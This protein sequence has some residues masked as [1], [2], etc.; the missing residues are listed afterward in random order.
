M[1]IL[2]SKD[3]Q[4]HYVNDAERGHVWEQIMIMLPKHVL[5][6]MLSAT[7]PNK[8]D[9]ADWLG[10]VRGTEVHVVAT[11]KRPVPLE[12][13]LFTGMDGQRSKDH[14]HLIVDQAGQF[15]LPGYKQ[16]SRMLSGE[17]DVDKK[18]PAENPVNSSNTKNVP[19]KNTGGKVNT[20]GHF[21][22]LPPIN[23]ISVHDH[24]TKNLW[25][26]VVHLLQER[27]LMPA[28]AFAFSRSSLETLAGH[29]SSVD[30]L[31]SSEK[32]Q[33]KNFLHCSVTKRL[34]R[35]DRQLASVQFIS[36][37]AVRGLAVHHAGMLPILKETVEMLFRRGL[38]RILFA[39]ETFAMGVN[40]P[41]RCV[42]FTT[43]EK[44]DGQKRRPLSSSE[45]TQMAG[46]AGR[47][48]LDASG[49]VI[50]LLGG[51]GKSLTPGSFGLPSEHTLNDIILGRQTQL[52]SKFK[53]TYSMI[54]HLHRTN[55]LTP[56]DVMR[57]S[58]M[59]AANLRRELERR[60]WLSALNKKLDETTTLIPPAGLSSNVSSH[61]LVRGSTSKVA[62]SMNSSSRLSVPIGEPILQVKCP[63]GQISC[64]D[65]M[66]TYYQACCNYQK[67]TAT[68]VRLLAEE[69]IS[70]LQRV[71][72]PGRIVFVHLPQTDHSLYSKVPVKQPDWLV[73]GV[74]VNLSKKKFM[75][76]SEIQWDIIT[77]QLPNLSNHS[78]SFKISNHQSPIQ[79]NSGN[80][81]NDGKVES[82]TNN[83]FNELDEEDI[84]KEGEDSQLSNTP[85]PPQ[86]MPV[87]IPEAT[88]ARE[89]IGGHLN[90]TDLFYENILPSEC[91]VTKFG[92]MKTEAII[93]RAVEKVRDSVFSKVGSRLSFNRSL[94]KPGAIICESQ[95]VDTVLDASLSVVSRK[96]LADWF[97]STEI[98]ISPSSHT[99]S[100]NHD[101]CAD[102][103]RRTKELLEKRIRNSKPRQSY[104]FQEDTACELP[105][106]TELVDNPAFKWEFE[107]DTFQKQAILCLE[108]NQTVFVAA[109]TSAGKTVVAEYAC[110]L[111]Q[112][113]GTRVIYTSPIKAL[114]NQKFYDFRQTFGDD[115]GLITG[116]IKLAPESTILVM[117]TEIL[118]NMLCNDAD[119]IRDLEIV[120]MDEVHYVN[121]AE[122]GHVWE[123]IMIMLPKHVLLVMLSATVPN[124]L[125]FADWL[126]RV[127]GTEVHVVATNKRPVPLEHFLFTGMD[128]Q[129]SKDHLHLIVDQAGQFNLPGK[130]KVRRLVTNFEDTTTELPTLKK[131][132]PNP[133]LNWYFEL[134]TFQKR[135]ILCLENN[136]TVFVA[137]HTS[138]G[139]TV[140]AEYACAICLRRGSRVIYTSPV[141]ALSNQ[142]FHDFREKFGENVGIIT[143]DIKLAPT[144][145]LLVMTTEILHSILCNASETINDLE[146][147]ILDEVHYINNPDRGYIW[148]QIMIML[149]RHIL[150]VLLSAT[151]PNTYEL[152]DWLG[153]VRGCKIHVVATDR[154]PV[155]LEHYLYT[156]NI[157]QYA[158]HLHLI[159]DENGRFINSGYEAAAV[160]NN[161]R[162][163]TYTPGLRGKDGFSMLTK[164]TWLGFIN[165]LKEQD[166]MPVIAFIFSRSVLE[167]LARNLSSI[168]LTSQTEKKQINKFFSTNIDRLKKCNRKLGSIR[169]VRDLTR[170]GFA[171][172]HGGMLPLLKEIVEVL[173][174]KGLVKILFATETFSM[175]INTPARSV[176]FTS[177]EKFDGQNLRPLNP[178]EYTQMA[179]RAGRRGVDDKGHVIILVSTIRRSIKS[180]LTGLPTESTLRTM[181]L[182]AQTQLVSKFKVTYS[183]ILSLHRLSSLTPQDVM[184]RSFMEAASHRWETKQR[185]DL[186]L[187]NNKLNE[188][189]AISSHNKPIDNCIQSTQATTATSNLFKSLTN[190]LDVQVKCPNNGLECCHS[191]SQYYELC[192]K[193]RQLKNSIICK[194]DEKY[195]ESLPK[196]FCPG[197][198]ILFESTIKQCVWLVPAVII[199]Y[200]WEKRKHGAG[201]QLMLNT[202]HWTLPANLPN[203]STFIN[204]Q[205]HV[206]VVVSCGNT[207][208]T[209]KQLNDSKNSNY[210]E[211][212][213]IEE[214][215]IERS[216][217]TEITTVQVPPHLMPVFIPSS[218]EDGY[219]RLTHR[220][221]SLSDSLVRICNRIVTFQSNKSNPTD[222][223][224]DNFEF[225][226][227]LS[228]ILSQSIK[229]HN[230]QQLKNNQTKNNVK[231]SSITVNG[232]DHLKEI[233]LELCNCVNATIPKKSVNYYTTLKNIPKQIDFRKDLNFNI[234]DEEDICLF[235]A[236]CTLNDQLTMPLSNDTITTLNLINLLK[237]PNLLQHLN[238]VHQTIRRK[239][240]IKNIQNNLANYQLQLSNE[241]T[242][243][244]NVLKELGFIDSTT[245]SYCLSF[246][247]F[248]A[249]ELMTKEVLLTQL[250]LDNLIDNLLAP[251]IA[252]V[253][254]AF[255]SELRAQDI[256]GEGASSCY[257]QVLIDSINCNTTTTT[258]FKCH[259]DLKHIPRHLLPVFKTIL[260]R[261]YELEKLQ[262]LHHL[263]DP[264]LESRL[265]LQIV[266]SVHKWANGY[267][268]PATLSTCDLPEGLLIKSLLQLDELIRCICGVCRQFGN[269]ALGLKINEARSLIRRDIVCSP[270]LY[271]LQDTENCL[272]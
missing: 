133:A 41:A 14:L 244:L 142:K 153:R 70:D 148:E 185:Q 220:S 140:V 131:L 236:Y 53:I 121:D 158:S 64:C 229:Q 159:V 228:E 37:L 267:S 104:I 122:R 20:P 197:R 266:Q 45:Y 203:S 175:G 181:I 162:R 118:H 135:A 109:H 202:I 156:G 43:L 184:K 224:D 96:T 59:E 226:V 160:S 249:S 143:G 233:N 147:V 65:S 207:T 24:R 74:L 123:Q 163:L 52:V 31:N 58:F 215:I 234:T 81:A 1:T 82:N 7:V 230:H 210:N 19:R 8:L 161:T 194:L 271:V 165:L 179:G 188:T 116:D 256:T 87:Y 95:A 94:L 106:L 132:I 139:K 86:L 171:I 146:I 38:I 240:A 71:F 152:A 263:T 112:R 217:I 2:G 177:I 5:L 69:N 47:R 164:N 66:T 186:S 258:N 178:S 26:G 232:N 127:R 137:A 211:Y 154:R 57:R 98:N 223:D 219:S 259:E 126:G 238:L 209:S 225:N 105:P 62:I 216:R 168:D 205:G 29:L 222:N 9:F 21:R 110:A 251:D 262:R 195:P 34:K 36:K 242:G 80:N 157:E 173:F 269:H 201:N 46:R 265:N 23:G 193:Y 272:R 270:S 102:I 61:Q 261:A 260:T 227:H 63:F 91:G 18:K 252:A 198:L 72:C 85:Y 39:T 67:L 213:V 155:P 60:Q 221:I 16:A 174:Q 25:L 235:D 212:D 204:E 246:K 108:R 54:L 239:L 77:W 190:D 93:V 214:E 253:L 183:M 257:L 32:Q 3:T 33:V 119:V 254:S 30:L 13:F 191:I 88:I 28:I 10:R 83:Q 237:C 68:I 55:W 189:T 11:N 248:F 27:D 206:D 92:E 218:L 255:A 99:E 101:K 200:Y 124:K 250:L 172:H 73:P 113:R 89:C 90:C 136:K 247:G 138:S 115:V 78:K 97:G 40:M 84:L 199:N 144:A 75:N 176:V 241:Y 180:P 76:E 141:K 103:N 245:Q 187:L 111:C 166:L 42:I 196:I 182:G 149:P 48:G 15:N 150:L 264:Y 130:Y 268:F 169:F 243:R 17:K 51:I 192:Y 50:I 170:R 6:V 114:S 129:R 117:T 208:I 35:C 79:I 120:I 22:P 44:F 107:L 12:H 125:D 231:L 128:G 145:S 100:L 56:Q 4:V 49:S 134:D 167:T 151:V